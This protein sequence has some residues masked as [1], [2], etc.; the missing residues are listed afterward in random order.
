VRL[1]SA[2]LCAALVAGLALARHPDA[3][4][5]GLQALRTRTG[6]GLQ[7][8]P[9]EVLLRD[10][11]RTQAA[12]SHAELAQL[13]VALYTQHPEHAL[14]EAAYVHAMRAHLAA[15]DAAAAERDLERLR[16]RHARSEFLPEALLELA[17]AQFGT[18][19]Y[20]AAAGT[21]TDLVALVTTGADRPAGSEDTAPQ[22]PII[23]S[24]RRW[25]EV[26][27]QERS[28]SQMERLARFNQAL[29][30]A[31]GGDREAAVRAYDR[32]LSRFPQ[33]E[34][35]AETHFQMAVLQE[36]AGHLDQAVQHFRAAYDAAAATAEGGSAPAGIRGESLYRAGRLLQGLHRQGEAE[37]TLRLALTVRPSDDEFRLSALAEL[38]RL[39][40][41]REPL[42][43]LDLYRELAEHSTRPA[44]RA[45]AL[46]RLAVLESESAVAAAGR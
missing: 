16:S 18:G 3:V 10:I 7:P 1:R 2:F 37:A 42:R 44:W 29:S 38:A 45:V 14:A 21:Y 31:R 26:K 32:F 13:C 19:A 15:G 6:G 11:E 34:R 12:G 4:T 25:N 40:E 35:A 24:L 28:R 22:P 36:E 33:D 20:G 5:G 46:E 43:A 17:S 8:R 9:V 23:R 30:F 39:V 41:Q 27:R